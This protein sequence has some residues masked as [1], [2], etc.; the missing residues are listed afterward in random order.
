MGLKVTPFNN[1]AYPKCT[2]V[3]TSVFR[4]GLVLKPTLAQPYAYCEIHDSQY[5]R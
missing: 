2:H 1:E 4:H 3:D 5:T